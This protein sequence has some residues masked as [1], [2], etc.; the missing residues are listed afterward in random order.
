MAPSST[1]RA[2]CFDWGEAPPKMRGRRYSRKPSPAT[3][4]N[5]RNNAARVAKP[6]SAGGP[7]SALLVRRDVAVDQIADVVVV[8]L[9]LLEEGIV[10]GVCLV[11]DVDVFG[12]GLDD[13]LLAR[14]DLIE[15]HHVDPDRS[16]KLRVFPVFLGRRA[17]AGRALEDGPA[18][19]ADDWIPVKIEEFGAAGLTL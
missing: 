9:F 10:C 11:L 4:P 14:L 19:R 15:R 7:Q 16:R 8:R 6:S 5:P 3:R 17:G 13:L 12:D 18:F 1:C 2:G